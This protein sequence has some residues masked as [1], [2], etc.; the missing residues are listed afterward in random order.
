MSGA[1][2]RGTVGDGLV[3]LSL[4][5]AHFEGCLSNARAAFIV[6]IQLSALF[7]KACCK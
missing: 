2:G 3:A 6:V 4:S 5:G 7:A 1:G